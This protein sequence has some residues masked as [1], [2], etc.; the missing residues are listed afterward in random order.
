MPK[1]ILILVE[2]KTEEDFIKRK[3]NPYYYS[4]EVYI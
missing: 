3:L 2:G 1:K 4:K